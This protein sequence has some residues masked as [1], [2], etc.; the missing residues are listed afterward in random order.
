MN[1]RLTAACVLLA[2]LGAA[3]QSPDADLGTQ[4]VMTLDGDATVVPL[5]PDHGAVLVVGFS[6]ESNPE[7]QAWSRRLQ[8]TLGTSAA[9]ADVPF[10][11]IIVLAGAPRLVRGLIRRGIR[12]GVP[13]EQHGLYYIVNED[14][15]FW[16]ALA[17]VDDEDQVHVLRVDPAGRTCRR[18]VGPVT[19]EAL[20]GMLEAAC[21]AAGGAS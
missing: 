18:H 5:H 13:R 12:S 14:D 19:D 21:P 2:G 4:T 3:A 7:A 6:Q 10:F 20:A 16:L 11:N 9:E 8:A 17:A 15:E 1:V